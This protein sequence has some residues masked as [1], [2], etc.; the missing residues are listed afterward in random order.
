[1]PGQ[2]RAFYQRLKFHQYTDGLFK[3]LMQL[4]FQD[5]NFLRPENLCINPRAHSLSVDCDQSEYCDV[6]I[7]IYCRQKF[8]RFS[9]ITTNQ[10]LSSLFTTANFRLYQ[11]KNWLKCDRD[12]RGGNCRKYMWL[13]TLQWTDIEI[14]MFWLHSTDLPDSTTDQ[15]INICKVNKP[16][17]FL[18]FAMQI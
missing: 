4:W 6:D 13:L 1:M 8:E 15:H 12:L 17:K 3:H 18:G 16:G 5:K 7:I 9:K 10:M 11:T 14:K 2:S